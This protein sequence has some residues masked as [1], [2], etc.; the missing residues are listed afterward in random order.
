M[1]ANLN[2]VIVNYLKEAPQEYK[3]KVYSDLRSGISPDDIASKISQAYPDKYSAKIENMPTVGVSQNN[4]SNAQ[5]NPFDTSSLYQDPQ[6]QTAAV[7][8]GIPSQETTAPGQ[9]M[10]TV[11]YS[12]ETK[13]NAFKQADSR[14]AR[15]QLR[16]QFNGPTAAENAIEGVKSGATEF[17][18]G[19]KEI[20]QLQKDKFMQ[21]LQDIGNL[22]TG[23]HVDV[24]NPNAA[25]DMG[26]LAGGV[27]NMIEGGMGAAYAV[28]GAIANEIPGVKQVLGKVGEFN[29]TTANNF[30]TNL[31]YDLNSVEGKR[32]TQ[33]VRNFL[34]LAEFH[35]GGK[36]AESAPVKGAI[37]GG[38]ELLQKAKTVAAPAVEKFNNAVG[39]VGIKMAKEVRRDTLQGK[40][41]DMQKAEDVAGQIT[42]ADPAQKAAAAKSL[43]DLPQEAGK[44]Y[45]SLKQ[46]LDDKAN[47]LKSEVDA[48]LDTKKGTT[49]L[50][51]LSH[52]VKVG[53]ETIKHNY[54]DDAFTQLEKHYE[55]VNEPAKLAKL[56]QLK[57]KAQSEGL[58]VKE[59][60]NLAREHGSEI[61][62]FSATGNAPS[63]LSKIAAENTRTGVK[64]TARTIFGDESYAATDKAY[65]SVIKTRDMV[66]KM[67]KAV[68]KLQ[69]KV[70]KR[71]LGQ[72]AGRLIAGIANTIS[73][74]ALKGALEYFVGRGAGLKTLNA[75]DL[76]A[77][78][79][80]NLQSLNNALKEGASKA[81][82]MKELESLDQSLMN[83]SKTPG[84]TLP[85]TKAN[86][87][88][89]QQINKNIPIEES[90]KNKKPFNKA[91]T[92][93]TGIVSPKESFINDVAQQS[94]KKDSGTRK[95]RYG[96][97]D[98]TEATAKI[99]AKKL[100]SAY[101]TEPS[102][103]A[104]DRFVIVREKAGD[105]DGM[106][107][108]EYRSKYYKD[109][110]SLYKST[111]NYNKN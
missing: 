41:A 84:A 106:S 1:P 3:D 80:K 2:P 10:N 37:K 86:P 104:K 76:E 72:K 11:N 36:V 101:R 42:Q 43:A 40:L 18:Q 88:A 74:G 47:S 87:T 79:S 71:G 33:A 78:L 69:Q 34:N 48:K 77:M 90:V 38:G 14:G 94:Y 51:D 46:A 31:G 7:K 44:D 108:E 53:E 110:E 57:S 5:S 4:P 91:A 35:L 66:T 59:I 95:I 61:K 26:K 23:K 64:Q 29:D 65:S 93:Q 89:N 8:A 60:N 67:E 54:V 96:D 9:S 82:I 97:K 21:G 49:L 73:G 25:D 6:V 58:T 20:G 24:V 52:E 81:D 27:G 50:D 105:A 55:A 107:F 99:E 92:P 28:P 45:K 12:T 100:G 98:Y 16:E 19:A 39:D 17:G 63:G 103:H 83:Q 32:V 102:P 13:R 30:A 68:N 111:Q 15:Q 22:L 75:L 85:K 56:N 109:F 70:M 62:A